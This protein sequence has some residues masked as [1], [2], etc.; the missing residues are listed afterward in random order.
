MANDD[1][2]IRR[3]DALNALHYDVGLGTAHP[4]YECIAAL[5]AVTVGVKPPFYFDRYINGVRMAED[6]CIERE[7]TLES[8]MLVAARIASKGPNGEA[9]VLVYSAPVTQP[10]PDAAMRLETVS[11]NIARDMHEGRFPARSE[12]QMVPVEPAPDAAA[13]RE[14][15]LREAA[16]VALDFEVNGVCGIQRC[17]GR[18]INESILALLTEKPHDRA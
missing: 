13:I 17:T 6:V 8:A 10:A 4:A 12:P 14:V 9:P 1:D 5:P 16:K 3:G 11:E 18:M 15:A 7:T 2:L